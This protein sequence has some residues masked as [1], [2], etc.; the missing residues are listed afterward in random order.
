VAVGDG[1]PIAEG[2]FLAS[3][4]LFGEDGADQAL[5]QKIADRIASEFKLDTTRHGTLASALWE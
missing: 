1:E 4:Y 5:A 2:S 3:I